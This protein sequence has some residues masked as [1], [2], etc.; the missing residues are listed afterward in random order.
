ML[1]FST[2][3]FFV[4]AMAVFMSLAALTCGQSREEL[5]ALRIDRFGKKPSQEE[6]NHFWSGIGLNIAKGR[7]R[8]I[9]AEKVKKIRTLL[10]PVFEIEKQ[11][12]K[13]KI[14]FSDGFIQ[15]NKIL[16]GEELSKQIFE[17][18]GQKDGL[19]L[20]QQSNMQDL[21]MYGSSDSPSDSSYLTWMKRAI[22][23]TDEQEKK[24]EALIEELW[25]RWKKVEK[26]QLKKLGALRKE[27]WQKI[28]TKLTKEQLK[29]L[30]RW[31][32]PWIPW[33]EIGSGEMTD[34]MIVHTGI[35]IGVLLEEEPDSDKREKKRLELA[36]LPAK[37]LRKK[38]FYPIN[39][40]VVLLMREEDVW[41]LLKLSDKQREELEKLTKAWHNDA[42]SHELFEAKLV[43]D[44]LEGKYVLPERLK[45]ILNEKQIGRFNQ[46]LLQYA[47]RMYIDGFGLTHPKISKK[48]QLNREQRYAIRKLKRAQ[49]AKVRELEKS[50]I[51]QLKKAKRELRGKILELLDEK[52][53]ALYQKLT[54][55]DPQKE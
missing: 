2:P 34:W 41:N 55:Y 18:L 39:A 3:F 52:Q 21:Q 1:K 40:D 48:L 37:E 49:T 31:M 22:E 26:D 33:T 23:L 8:G 20:V 12:Q 17:V 53:M 4:F 45:P 38:G 14:E 9:E 46:I 32:G 44:L 50:V 51:P 28:K 30:E 35:K 25:T 19:K 27:N 7:Y 10:N 29:S 15:K 43:E 54:G 36:K 6:T 42:F 24:K 47:T 16:A 5:T 11:M 13:G